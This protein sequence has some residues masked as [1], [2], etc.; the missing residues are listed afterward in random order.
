MKKEQP[1][2]R[3][4]KVDRD[5]RIL[6]EYRSAREAARKNYLSTNTVVNRCLGKVKEPYRLDGCDYKYKE[7]EHANEK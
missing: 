4:V 3:V 6:A 7:E 5:G 1:I 2:R